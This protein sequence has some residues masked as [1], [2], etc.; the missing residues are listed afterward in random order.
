MVPVGSDLN[1]AKM[2]LGNDMSTWE[3]D[4]LKVLQGILKKAQQEKAKREKL[5]KTKSNIQSM[6]EVVLRNTVQAFLD[7]HPEFCDEFNV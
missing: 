4:D 3:I 6:N 1:K 7:E 5:T 2:Q